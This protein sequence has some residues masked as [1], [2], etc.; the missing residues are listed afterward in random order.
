VSSTAPAAIQRRTRSIS[1]AESGFA[2]FG[3]SA[4]PLASGVICESSSLPSG[5]PG[6]MPAF[7]ESPAAII[8]FT[9]VST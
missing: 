6:T 7:P 9:S 3:I 5:F 4:R 8:R 1:P 2:F